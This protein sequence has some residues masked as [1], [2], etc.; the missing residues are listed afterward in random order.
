VSRC[1]QFLATVYQALQDWGMQMSIPK[2]K[3]ICYNK[4][5]HCTEPVQ[6]AEHEIE[7][8]S[9]FKYLGSMQTSDLSVKAEVSNRLASAANAWLKL[10]KQHVWDDGCISRGIKC[11]LYKVIVQSTLPYASHYEV[12]GFHTAFTSPS[13]G[14]TAASQGF[15]TTSQTSEVFVKHHIC[16]TIASYCMLARGGLVKLSQAHSRTLHASI[17]AIL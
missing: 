7:Q 12:A 6:V 9:K 4:A 17:T 14:F 5:Q 1:K 8:V 13:Q 10:S 15:T 2:T 3:Y 16:F 11:T